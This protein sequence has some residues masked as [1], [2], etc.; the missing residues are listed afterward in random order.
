M[1]HNMQTTG[2]GIDVSKS[3]LDIALLDNEG[4]V[5][6]FIVPNDE[7][8]IGKIA[9]RVKGYNGKII[10]ESTGRYH[11]LS[12][13]RLYEAGFDVRIINPLISRK[14]MQAGIRKN[15]TDKADACKLAEI[16]VIE[17]NLPE[18]F[19]ADKGA[20]RIRQKIGLIASLETQTQTLKAI[21]NNYRDFQEQLKI[22]GS[23]AEKAVAETVSK[24]NAAKIKLEKEIE[25]LISQVGKHNKKQKILTSVPG[26]SDYAASLILQFFGEN[27]NKSAKQWIAYAG[28]DVSVKQSGTWHGKGRLSKRGN[29]YLRKRLY[30]A[31]W[32]ATMHSDSFRRYYDELK[33]G[34]RKHTEALVIIARKLIRIAF[35]LLKNNR[36]FNEKLCFSY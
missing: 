28:M 8:G 3:K 10:M 19:R 22:S 33:E 30:C 23:E 36:L 2:I 11:L 4:G 25:A 26:I 16:A 7:S 9:E 29:A 17:K 34:G 5:A 31:A 24:L 1:K 14:Y 12:A 6:H 18:P 15:K 20:I 32:G 13:M 27:Y 35:V 21:M